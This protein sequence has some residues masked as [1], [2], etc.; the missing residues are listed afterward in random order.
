MP[1]LDAFSQQIVDLVRRMPDDAILELVKNQ[2][3]MDGAVAAPIVASAP[4]RQKAKPAAPPKRK[5]TKVRRKR[6]SRRS[7]DR[8]KALATV[9][10]AIK[11]S[12]GMSASQ[13]ASKTKLPQSRVSSLV[14]ELKDQKRVHQGGDRRFARYAGDAKTAA[15][16]SNDARNNAA[17]PKKGRKRR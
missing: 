8:E 10:T 5:A 17:G 6:S 9:E 14:R 13:I 7:A 12:K 11:S 15:K 1:Q 2:L 4:A 16:A 3:G